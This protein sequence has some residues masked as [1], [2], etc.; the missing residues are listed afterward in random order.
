MSQ[1]KHL[2]ALKLRVP[3]RRALDPDMR[4]Y[5]GVCDEKLALALAGDINDGKTVVALAR[6]ASKV[7]SKPSE[8]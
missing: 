4:K 5:F 6:A 2:T 8:P 3:L 1:P 7:K